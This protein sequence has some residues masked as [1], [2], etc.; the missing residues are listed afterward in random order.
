[1]TASTTSVRGPEKE[2]EVAAP[3]GGRVL[4]PRRHSPTTGALQT[5]T[6]HAGDLTH[7]R[8]RSRRVAWFKWPGAFRCR[9]P[10]RTLRT[11]RRRSTVRVTVT[12]DQVRSAFEAV[13]DDPSF[14]ESRGLWERG[15]PPVEMLQAMCLRPEILRAFGGFGGGVYPG[16]LLERR[17]QG[18][19]DH[20]GLARERRA[21]SARTRTATS[22]TSA[23]ILDDAAGADRRAGVARRRASASPSSTRGPRWPTRTRSPSRCG[24]SC[25]S[26]SP[27]RSSSSSRS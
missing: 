8:K 4:D 2:E 19:R 6:A 12:P 21:S 22:S 27:I 15:Q 26:A 23:D 24:P 11:T 25:T 14:D 5:H 20:H 17:D 18:A 9:R 13:K 1:M 3:S 16:G 10:S 7:G